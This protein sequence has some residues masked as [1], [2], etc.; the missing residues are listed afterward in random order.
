MPDFMRIKDRT[1]GAW[2]DLFS[3]FIFPGQSRSGSRLYTHKG[4]RYWA[5]H[6]AVRMFPA[7]TVLWEETRRRWFMRIKPRASTTP[8]LSFDTR[9]RALESVPLTDFMRINLGR[10]ANARNLLSISTGKITTAM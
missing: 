10:M 1:R 7:R 8:S 2:A 5:T 6:G 9:T 3:Q 4:Q